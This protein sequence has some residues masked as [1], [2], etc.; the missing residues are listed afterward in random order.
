MNPT[1]RYVAART[2]M[3][4]EANKLTVMMTIV[5]ITESF[6]DGTILTSF[7]LLVLGV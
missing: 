7:L 2:D 5:F 1:Q 3:A 4:D 6:L